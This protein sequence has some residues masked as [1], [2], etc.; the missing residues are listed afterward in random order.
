MAT[1]TKQ[2]LPITLSLT[3]FLEFLMSQNLKK[4]NKM[5][6]KFNNLIMFQVSPPSHAIIIIKVHKLSL[7]KPI[8]QL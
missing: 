7:E 1:N 4:R 2:N 8:N 3:T 6:N 5:K